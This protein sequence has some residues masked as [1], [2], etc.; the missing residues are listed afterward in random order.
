[1]YSRNN[2]LE[3]EELCHEV[4]RKALCNPAVSEIE[5]EARFTQNLSSI[6]QNTDEF[7]ATRVRYSKTN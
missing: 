1:M 7:L 3:Y 4:S 5:N 2:M 6:E